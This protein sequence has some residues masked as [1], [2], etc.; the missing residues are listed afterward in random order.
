ME[1]KEFANEIKSVFP[2]RAIDL[3]ESIDLLK[4]VIDET[5]KDIG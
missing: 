3:Y 2:E 1:Y 4:A 5:V